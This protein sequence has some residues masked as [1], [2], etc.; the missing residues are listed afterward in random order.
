MY[1]ANVSMPAH[2]M[3]PVAGSGAQP[4]PRPGCHGVD[5]G[6]NEVRSSPAAAAVLMTVTF[7]DDSV[8]VTD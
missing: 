2:E 7:S 6:S 5:F 4:P 8:T 1:P 3:E